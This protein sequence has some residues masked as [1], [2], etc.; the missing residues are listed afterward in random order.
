MYEFSLRGITFS[1][2]LLL[3]SSVLWTNSM[4]MLRPHQAFA[5]NSMNIANLLVG[6]PIHRNHKDVNGTRQDLKLIGIAINPSSC[7][8]ST[9][10]IQTLSRG[11][12]N[13][14]PN[15]ANSG[16][17][18]MS[19]IQT[20]SKMVQSPTNPTSCTASTLAIQRLSNPNLPN[21]NP[22]NPNSGVVPTFATQTIHYQPVV[23]STNTK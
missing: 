9:V 12:P 6:D 20:F 16:V 1:C 10:P 14:N 21:S 13:A 5:Q 19:A 4:G 23:P 17:V 2:F 11:V 8:A 3:I 15:N 22:N 18:S 7:I